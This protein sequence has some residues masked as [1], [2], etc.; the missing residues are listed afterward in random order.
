[1]RV[2]SL[3]SVLFAAVVLTALPAAASCPGD[4]TGD[5]VVG[6]SELIRGVNIALGNAPVSDCPAFDVNVDGSV[7]VNELIAAVNA[8]LNG[9]PIEPIFPA[10][11]RDTFIEVRDCRQSIEHGFVAIRVLANPIA[12]GPYL[13]LENPLPV[14]SIIVKEEYDAQDCSNDADLVRWRP[15]RKEAPGFDPDDGDWAWQW[16]DAPSRSVRFDDKATCI[17]CH[18][19]EACLARDYMCTEAGDTPRGELRKVL[20]KVPAALLS[21]SGTSPTD[22]YTVGADPKDGRGPFVLQYDG[23]SWKRLDSG[24]SGDLWWISVTPI[25]GNFYLAGAGGLIL[26]FDPVSKAFTR[27][28][29]PGTPTLFG[30]WGATATDLW[31]VGEGDE[32]RG[33]LWHYDGQT[34]EARDLSAVAPDGVPTLF[35]IWG[36]SATDIYAVGQVG[37]ILHYDGVQWSLLTSPV[38]QD[39][40]T[41]HGSGSRLAAAGGFF[42]GVLLE[43]QSP[44]AFQKRAL[45]GVAQLN[46][47]FV[48]PSGQAI[49]VGNGLTVAVRDG[50]GW[51]I[52]QDADDDQARDFHAVWIDADDG[53]WA[54]GG[55]LSSL[56]NGVLAYG[57]PQQVIGGPVQ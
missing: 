15:M 3:V 57:G 23:H 40:F 12:A 13:R 33:V 2:L 1:M 44:L 49:A 30:V 35:K 45:P 53:V 11:Y 8:A 38:A 36:R 4:C 52:A 6:V 55:D 19:A 42:T 54:V 22:I 50:A 56:T 43:E 29:T 28:T 9:C 27:H 37:T 46:G 16:V 10:D 26:Q 47:V 25:D 14:G 20:E 39:L 51:S 21:I 34:W 41:V 7:A 17:G 32:S 24:A 31:A 48:P 5:G 18:R